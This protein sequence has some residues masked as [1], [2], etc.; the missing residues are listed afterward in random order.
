M[1]W[2][3]DHKINILVQTKPKSND[4]E[5]AD[6]PSVQELARNENDRRVIDL[7]VAGDAMGKPMAI[8]PNAPAERAQALRDA[9]EATLRDPEFIEAVKKARVELTPVPG[10]R[11][12]EIVARVLTTPPELKARAR[13]II[14]E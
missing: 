14:A 3:R 9:Y 5:L 8:A 4:S 2:V 12:Q 1:D 6:V 10:T 13:K 11:L 7:V